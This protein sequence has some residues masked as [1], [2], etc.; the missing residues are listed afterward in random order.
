MRIHLPEPSLSDELT[1]FLRRCEC[2]VT[3]LGE[4]VFEVDLR[5]A[6][7]Y[8]AAM[9]L[10]QAGRCYSCGEEIEPV[11]RDLGSALC[12]DCR[13]GENGNGNGHANVPAD[14]V[15]RERWVRMEVAA[16]LRTW[17]ALHADAQPRVLD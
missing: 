6:L 15:L 13:D 9:G 16:Y 14:S 3:A 12:H 10:V 4:G 11:L 2:N 5:L 17:S 7:S 8:D 1:E